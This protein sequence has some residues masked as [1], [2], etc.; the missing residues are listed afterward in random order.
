MENLSRSALLK[1]KEYSCDIFLARVLS[2]FVMAVRLFCVR[3]EQENRIYVF[4]FLFSQSLRF[5][6]LLPISSSSL[7]D[8]KLTHDAFYSF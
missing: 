2:L 4:L 1:N 6:C 3:I 5:F 7:R 8:G